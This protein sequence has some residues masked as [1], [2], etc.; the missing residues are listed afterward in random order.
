MKRILLAIAMLL[1]TSTN[2]EAASCEQADMTGRWW[3]TQLLSLHDEESGEVVATLGV[4][5]R[6]DVNESGDVTAVDCSSGEFEEIF[7]EEFDGFRILPDDKCRID[8]CALTLCYE[9]QIAT[10]KIQAAGIVNGGPLRGSFD[11]IKE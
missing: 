4:S 8:R 9:G 11:M 5:C 2:A 6:L 10:D 3:L 7:R 1:A